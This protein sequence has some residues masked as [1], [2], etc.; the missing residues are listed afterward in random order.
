MIWCFRSLRYWFVFESQGCAWTECAEEGRN[1]NEKSTRRKWLITTTTI[2]KQYLVSI[3]TLTALCCAIACECI[4]R[5]Y[6]KLVSVANKVISHLLMAEPDNIYALPDMTSPNS[7]VKILTTLCDLADR[8]LVAIIG[9]AKHIPG[10]QVSSAEK[11]PCVFLT[12]VL[13]ERFTQCFITCVAG[14]AYLSLAG[15]RRKRK[16]VAVFVMNLMRKRGQNYFI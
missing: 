15:W 4:W 14:F 9:W 11:A 13:C 8:E 2:R 7:N 6:S 10:I 1:T 5:P 12:F 3:Y 16:F